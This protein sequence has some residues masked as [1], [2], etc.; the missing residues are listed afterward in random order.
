M[1]FKAKV[2]PQIFKKA[3]YAII[4]VSKKGVLKIIKEFKKLSFEIYEK[5]RPK[6]SP[7]DIYY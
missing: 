1:R 6:H 5:K 7:T 3:R 4:N 2:W